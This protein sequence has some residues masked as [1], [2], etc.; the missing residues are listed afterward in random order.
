[1]NGN[2][3]KAIR[4]EKVEFWEYFVRDEKIEGKD[5]CETITQL[6]GCK[7]WQ[8]MKKGI[9]YYGFRYKE[10]IYFMCIDKTRRGGRYEI[11]NF[12]LKEKVD[13]TID[14]SEIIQIIEKCSYS[15]RDE[16]K[17][18][19]GWQ[20]FFKYNWGIMAILL[21]GGGI[22]CC[23]SQMIQ[24]EHVSIFATY[25]ALI[26]A[27]E[28]CYIVMAKRYQKKFNRILAKVIIFYLIFLEISACIFM[29]LSM[30]NETLSSLVSIGAG[31][32]AIITTVGVL[33]I[34]K[35]AMSFV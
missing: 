22:V 26:L 5:L 1:M 28:D 6:K 30:L 12:S 18:I 15:T 14:Y 19:H 31:G 11:F 27:L 8:G 16:V 4:D 24:V 20:I 2:L 23:F 34:R 9:E 29:F 3:E 17:R 21:C 10:E 13:I 25:I 32:M 35:E 7:I 33:L